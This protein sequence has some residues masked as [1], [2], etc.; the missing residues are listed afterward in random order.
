MCL[1]KSADENIAY[2]ITQVYRY[3]HNYCDKIYMTN[4]H[5]FFLYS[6]RYQNL[7]ELKNERIVL[8][9]K[10]IAFMHNPTKETCPSK[11]RCMDKLIQSCVEGSVPK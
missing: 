6:L 10:H 8:L 7:S 9:Y 2:L 11:D 5:V 4:K 3:S 1:I